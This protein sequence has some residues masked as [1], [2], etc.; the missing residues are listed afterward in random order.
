MSSTDVAKS[1]RAKNLSARH[2]LC[3]AAR[4]SLQFSS[5]Q[6]SSLLQLLLATCPDQRQVLKW[7]FYGY[8][9]F[10]FVCLSRFGEGR[11]KGDSA[12]FLVMLIFYLL[13]VA[14]PLL[15]LC[16]QVSIICS[17]HWHCWLDSVVRLDLTGLLLLALPF[18]LLGSAVLEILSSSFNTCFDCL[19]LEVFT[20]FIFG[21]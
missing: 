21:V 11:K 14:L 7:A 10:N 19:D 15:S 2:F 5:V 8:I 6:F 13:T 1:L 4:L 17:S 3:L 9:I 12:H 16:Y 20:R 18:L